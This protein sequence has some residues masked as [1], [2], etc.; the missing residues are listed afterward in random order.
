MAPREGLRQAVEAIVGFHQRMLALDA[1]FH[2]KYSEHFDL[3]RWVDGLTGRPRGSLEFLLWILE[4]EAGLDARHDRETV[5]LLVNHQ[6][7][8]LAE[9]ARERPEALDDPTFVETIVEMCMAAL[10]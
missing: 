6:L 10:R 2:R 7:R 4:G 3:S 9:V 1:P 8:A 5:A